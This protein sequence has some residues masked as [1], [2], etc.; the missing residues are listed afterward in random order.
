[1][2]LGRLVTALDILR[3][4]AEAYVKGAWPI[5]EPE[6]SDLVATLKILPMTFGR[7]IG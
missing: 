7:T 3:A 4:Y 6:Y 1:M 2:S 5:G